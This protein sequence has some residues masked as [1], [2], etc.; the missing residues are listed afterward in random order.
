MTSNGLASA[1]EKKDERQK[2]RLASYSL[3]LV[4]LRVGLWEKTIAWA[5]L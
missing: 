5:L 1:V 3:E 2:D 4:K